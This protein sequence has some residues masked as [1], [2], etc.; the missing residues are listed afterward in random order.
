M[1]VY[2][3]E[4]VMPVSGNDKYL[5]RLE[6]FKK[7][8][9]QCVGNYKV[10]LTL[11]VGTEKIPNILEGWAD[12]LEIRVISSGLDHCASKVYNYYSN[13]L[14]QYNN[15]IKSNWHMRIDDDSMT[16]VNILMSNIEDLDYENKEYYLVAELHT[17]DSTVEC[18]LIEKYKIEIKKPIF[19]EVECCLAS[20]KCLQTALNTPLIKN[21]F[22]DRA[23]IEQ[24]YTDICFTVALRTIGLFPMKVGFLCSTYDTYAF[25][26]EQVAHIHYV[27]HD[28]NS[29]QYKFFWGRVNKEKLNIINKPILFGFKYEDDTYEVE[30]RILE[31]GGKIKSRSIPIVWT[32]RDNML[33]ILS[34]NDL[35]VLQEFEIKNEH[36]IAYTEGVEYGWEDTPRIPFIKSLSLN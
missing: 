22:A 31:E 3:I 15:S 5:E 18:G 10:L 33:S 7:T 12:E 6:D 32:Y 17:G 35:N 11:L 29:S 20:Y 34:A 13:Y 4:F 8:G 30:Y 9:L 14:E 23:Q 26:V 19:H 21:L 25:I 36:P 1:K 24:G 2:D 28:V 16:N 27:E